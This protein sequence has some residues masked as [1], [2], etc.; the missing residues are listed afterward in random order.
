LGLVAASIVRAPEG[1]ADRIAVQVRMGDRFGVTSGFRAWGD[2]AER[3]CEQAAEAGEE[4][5][6]ARVIEAAGREA[7]ALGAARLLGLSPVLPQ[8]VEQRCRVLAE[9]V[10]RA[11]EALHEASRRVTVEAAA[12][13]LNAHL[14]VRRKSFHSGLAER[15]EDAVRLVRWL[16]AKPAQRASLADHAAAYRDAGAWV[17]RAR[18]GLSRGLANAE[19][20]A[21]LALLGGVVRDRR[22]E[23]SRAFAERLAVVTA[24][25]EGDGGVLYLEQLYREV[26]AP[27]AKAAPVLVV[28]MDG[29]SQAVFQQLAQDVEA[30]TSLSRIAPEDEPTWRPVIAPLPTVTEVC[31]A[32]LLCGELT[33]GPASVER[34]GLLALAEEFRW[35]RGERGQAFVFHKGTMHEGGGGLAPEVRAAIEGEHRVVTVVVNAVDDQLPKASQIELRWTLDQVPELKA[36]IACAEAEQRAIVLTADHGHVVETWDGEGDGRH[37]EEK[38]ERWRAIG[39]ALSEMEVEVRGRRV[40]LPDSPGSA[41]AVVLPWSERLRYS[42]RHA[43][44]HGGA[45]PQEVVVPLGVF[46]P[47]RLA[48]ELTGWR[49]EIVERPRWWAHALEANAAEETSWFR[50]E[51]PRPTARRRRAPEPSL[52]PPPGERTSPPSV[53]ASWVDALLATEIYRAQKRAAQRQRPD[54]AVVAAFL[55][56]LDDGGGSATLEGLRNRLGL[57]PIRFTGVLSL[58]QKLLN[59]DGFAVLEVNRSEGRVTLDRDQLQRQFRLGERS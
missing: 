59:V 46:A 7:E 17:D 26:V 1:N 20:Q 22:E 44:Y 19:L 14:L 41:N 38:G 29:M 3:W 25:G 51:P 4:D 12:R 16:A 31:R 56:T 27:L 10:Q 28:V 53:E 36:L 5:E 37:G 49:A 57:L 54:D 40:L 42:A 6:L 8:G 48:E 24:G 52:F 43:G 45:S 58:M 9:G 47:Q 15:V 30:R 50:P 2:A 32:S 55:R 33:V 18:H 35:N 11:V 34:A 39:R 21:A 23:E 13:D